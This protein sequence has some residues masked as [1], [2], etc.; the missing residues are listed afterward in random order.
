MQPL[1]GK[2]WFL[3]ASQPQGGAP[4]TLG[5]YMQPLGAKI[6]TT[7][8]HLPDD[9]KL[10]AIFMYFGKYRQQNLIITQ[11]VFRVIVCWRQ[12]FADGACSGTHFFILT[13]KRCKIR[14]YQVHFLSSI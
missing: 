9:P 12:Q 11:T 13:Q 1:Q 7:G 10:T 4:L 5:Y 14:I 2:N 8:T 3:L 6:R